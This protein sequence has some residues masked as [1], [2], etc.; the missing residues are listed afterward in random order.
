MNKKWQYKT[1]QNEEETKR[2]VEKFN[3]NKTLAQIMVNRGIT[4][5][6]AEVFLNPKRNDFYNPFEMPD[7]EK[8]AAHNA[9][10]SVHKTG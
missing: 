5:D 4:V 7:M 9:T 2:I 6:T 3:I 10:A 1:N 8:A